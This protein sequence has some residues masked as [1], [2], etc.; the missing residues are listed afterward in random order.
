MEHGIDQGPTGV[1]PHPGPGF[2]R[3]L[4]DQILAKRYVLYVLFIAGIV[5]WRLAPQM[6]NVIK[7]VPGIGK[8]SGGALVISGVDSA[9]NFVVETV[10]Q[11]TSEYPKVSVEMA[12]GGTLAALENLLNR[13]ANVAVLSR[14]PTEREARIAGERGDSLAYFPVALGGIALLAPTASSVQAIT[15]GELRALVTGGPAAALPGKGVERFYGLSPNSGLWEALL[16][17]LELSPSLPPTYIPLESGEQ[18]LSA[19]RQDPGGIGFAS[20]LTY[21][22]EAAPGGVR[23]VPL[24]TE[25]VGTRLPTKGN[26]VDGTYPIF[27]NIYL[28]TLSGGEAIASGFVT[29]YTQPTGQKWVARRG[30]LPARLPSRVIQVSGGSAS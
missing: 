9:P 6:A 12:G 26:I 30:F 25:G 15:V 4:V 24:T 13:R 17:R 20:T 10:A 11:F 28:C 1:R 19:L 22:I 14:P 7:K 2:G 21:D 29:Y 18:V 3:W 8:A 23:E 16:A 5:A 27:H